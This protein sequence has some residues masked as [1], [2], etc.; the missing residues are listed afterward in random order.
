LTARRTQPWNIDLFDIAVSEHVFVGHENFVE[1]DDGI[2]FVEAAGKRVIEGTAGGG[3]RQLIGRPAEQF[4]AG[5]ICRHDAHES[6]ILGLDGQ[7]AVVGDEVVMGERG[8]RGDHLGAADDQAA[9]GFLLDMHVDVANLFQLL[10][11]VDRRIHDGVIDEGDFLLNL[12][13]PALGVVLEGSVKAGVGAERSQKSR[14]VVRA[15]AHPSV[16]DACPLGDGI[17]GAD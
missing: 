15:A 10:V 9:V 13:V 17:A 14:F 1:H 12:L 3:G 7:R 8:S 11:A 2:V 5:C 4:H 16:G 6:E